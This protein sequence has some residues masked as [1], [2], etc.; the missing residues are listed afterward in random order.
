MKSR[1]EVITGGG[2]KKMEGVNMPA[3]FKFAWRWLVGAT[4]AT[5]LCL[6][7]L[8][9]VG[10]AENIEICV[11]LNSGKIKGI[12]LGAGN[13]SGNTQELDWVTTGPSGPTGMQG[14]VGDLGLP[15]TQGPQGDPG[16]QGP[17]GGQGDAG[18]QGP[19]GA[20]GPTG[21]TGPA[22]IMGEDG[23]RGPTGLMGVTGPTGIPGISEPN[24]SVFTGGSL[25]TLGFL[26]NVDLSGNNS[27]GTPGTILIMGPGNGSDTSQATE[28]LMSEAGTAK[29][30]FVNVDNDPGTQMNNG[31]PSTFSFFLCNGNSFPGNCGLACFMV[32]PDTTCSDLTDTQTFV[33]T[34]EMSLWAF[35]DY[36]GANHAD[37]K[38]SVTYDHGAGLIIP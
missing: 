25:G 12:N 11:D 17:P 22:G 30:L 36:P 14:V 18:P 16:I 27:V 28:V 32:G 3:S 34:D 8:P 15:G 6:V 26:E 35:A 31:I 13:C 4:A 29:R 21:P 1:S 10:R 33:R 7:A 37:V 20:I 5:I 24:I 23:V 2:N 9:G 19:Q 38:W